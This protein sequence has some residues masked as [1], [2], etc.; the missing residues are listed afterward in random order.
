MFRVADLEDVGVLGDDVDLVR[1]H[2]LGDHRQTGLVAR[3]GQVAERLDAQALE[4]V[5]AR[6][7]LERATA[8]DRGAGRRDR[9]RPSP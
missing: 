3:L 5:R 8:D 1:L 7:R 9:R 4:R 6:A 2:H